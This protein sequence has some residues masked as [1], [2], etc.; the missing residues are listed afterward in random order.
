MQVQNQVG[1]YPSRWDITGTVVE[2][3]EHDQYIVKVHGSERLTTRNRKFLKKV[4]PY[5]S[6]NPMAD[7]SPPSDSST[8]PDPVSMFPTTLPSLYTGDNQEHITTTKQ[9]DVQ[10]S[11]QVKDTVTQQPR[12]SSRA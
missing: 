12:R 7:T 2:V 1:N 10:L 3:R 5:G 4:T 9:E 6:E 11:D 8:V